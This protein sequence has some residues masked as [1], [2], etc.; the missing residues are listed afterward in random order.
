MFI[1][2]TVDAE[3]ILKKFPEGW[4]LD[5]KV[6]KKGGKFPDYTDVYFVKK[7]KEGK[8]LYRITGAKKAEKFLEAY[9]E[10]GSE[11]LAA[12]NTSVFVS[13]IIK[14]EETKKRESKRKKKVLRSQRREKQ[15]NH[16][17]QHQPRQRPPTNLLTRK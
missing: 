6:R 1:N 3:K 7:N 14:K 8:V 10:N 11:F 13:K 2:M 16:Q 9:K 4:V 12:S 5:K 17:E 15:K